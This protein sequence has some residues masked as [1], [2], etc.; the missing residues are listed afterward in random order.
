MLL[1]LKVKNSRGDYL[2]MIE[3]IDNKP[4]LIGDDY[5]KDFARFV[6]GSIDKGITVLKD[7]YDEK[8][9]MFVMSEESISSDDSLFPTAFKE[10]LRR[11]GYNVVEKRPEVEE[12]IR[13]LLKEYPDN[14]DKKDILSRLSEISYLEQTL[15]IKGLKKEQA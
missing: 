7:Q 9:R 15:L 1:I 10:Y 12:E 2:G 4:Q 8:D 14:E 13:Q 5:D 6:R 11:S 3:F